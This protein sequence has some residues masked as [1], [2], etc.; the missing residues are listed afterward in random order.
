MAIKRNISYSILR[1]VADNIE[2]LAD[3]VTLPEIAKIAKS[4]GYAGK[5]SYEGIATYLGREHLLLI[6]HGV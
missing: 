6:K 4:R 3:H 2:K 5:S 1:S